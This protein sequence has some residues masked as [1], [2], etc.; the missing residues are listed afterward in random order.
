MTNANISPPQKKTTTVYSLCYKQ[1]LF[2]YWI[3]ETYFLCVNLAVLE[4]PLYTMMALNS[5]PLKCCI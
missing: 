4:L 5:L 1:Y 3:F 2:A